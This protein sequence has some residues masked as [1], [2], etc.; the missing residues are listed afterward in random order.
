L[1]LPPT[2]RQIRRAE[3]CRCRVTALVLILLGVCAPSP[4]AGKAEKG[5]TKGADSRMVWPQPPDRARIQFL[6]VFRRQADMGWKTSLWRKFKNWAKAEDDPSLL[7]RPIAVA[8]DRSGRILIADIGTRDIRIFDAKKK[9]VD[10][11]AGYRGKHFGNPV[12]LATDGEGN[13]YVSDSGAGRVL[14][15]GANGKLR[16]FV[17]GEEGGFKQPAAIAYNPVNQLLYIVDTMRPRVYAYSADDKVIHQFGEYGTGPGQFNLPAAI[18]I[19]RQG[20]LYV[21]DTMNFRV[22]VFTPEG[23]FV[24]QFGEAGDASGYFNRPKG[25]SLD[26]EG[27]IYITEAMFS[28]VQIFDLEGHYLLSFGKSGPGPGEFYIPAGITIDDSNR[29]YVTDTF[30]GRVQVFQYLPEKE[31]QRGGAE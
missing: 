4:A 19:D 24:T 31:S 5:D 29:I 25:L 16:G 20:R 26:S 18:A 3:A 17:G 15:F 10:R 2:V 14:K 13:I 9:T 6:E 21:N 1:V 12:S 23:K 22:Q 28:T 7:R 8:V 11:I 30:R 27:H